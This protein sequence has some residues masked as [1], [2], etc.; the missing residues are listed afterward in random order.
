MKRQKR[1][2][3][4]SSEIEKLKK[5]L[6]LY[7]KLALKDPLTGLYNRRGFL[8]ET[9][10]LIKMNQRLGQRFSFSLASFGRVGLVFIDL[11][12]FKH[13]NDRFGH[14]VGDEVL[15]EIAK[16]LEGSLRRFDIV[17]RWGGDEFVVAIWDVDKKTLDIIVERLKSKI[18]NEPII[19]RKQPIS[20]T[21]SFGAKV[22]PIEGLELEKEIEG[23][24]KSM[25][26][27]KKQS[28][29]RLTSA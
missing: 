24:D 27:A 3:R 7:K 21:A 1:N 8:E 5:E 16:R 20:I 11:D 19:I 18:T 22:F 23:V 26:R 2:Q 6:S 13:I 25:Y 29:N 12:N 28:K 9:D 14:K 15:K 4:K 17:G 10:R